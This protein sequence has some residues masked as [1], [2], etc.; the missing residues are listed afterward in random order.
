MLL[1]HLTNAHKFLKFVK[2]EQLN[3][4]LGLLTQISAW[5]KS[6][7]YSILQM[8]IYFLDLFHLRNG[9]TCSEF[10]KKSHLNL[11]LGLFTHMRAWIKIFFMVK[12]FIAFFVI[13]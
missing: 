1:F 11:N 10:V 2:K 13:F 12:S 8:G 4:G 9:G 7:V 3:L 5:I 6:S